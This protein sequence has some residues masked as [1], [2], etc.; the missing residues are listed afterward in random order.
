MEVILLEK[1]G[2]LGNL[3]DKV[4]VKNG[5]A[6]N[7]LIPFKKALRVNK[8]NLEYFE[9]KKQE[10]ETANNAAKV[11]A[12]ADAEKIKGKTFIVIRQA[13]DTGHLY[14][15]VNSRDVSEIL[16]SAGVIV[17]YSKITIDTPI[18][19]IGIYSVKVALHPE[20]VETVKLNVARTEEE[21]KATEQKLKTVAK[22]DSVKIEKE[23]TVAKESTEV[24]EKIENETEM[25]K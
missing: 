3:G 20:V 10:L 22:K 19:E 4:S 16:K 2:K 13:G 7:F 21:A 8:A 18:R 23:T 15:S 1:I 25:K 14:G 6:R 5:F 17:S 24:T 12:T 9:T 11:K